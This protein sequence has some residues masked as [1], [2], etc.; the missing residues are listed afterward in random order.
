[1]YHQPEAQKQKV[2]KLMRLRYMRRKTLEDVTMVVR[3]HFGPHFKVRAFGSTC[4]GAGRS[5]SDVDVCILVSKALRKPP[6]RLS[7]YDT[8]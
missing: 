5:D 7:L 3:K 2:E 6:F 8:R 1:M 4:Y